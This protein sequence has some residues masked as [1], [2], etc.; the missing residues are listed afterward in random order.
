MIQRRAFSVLRETL[1]RKASV[2]LIGPRQVGKTT[3]ALSLADSVGGT[4]WD[5]ERTDVQIIFEDISG[6]FRSQEGR[7]VI[8][9]EVHR[10]PKLFSSIRGVIDR[11]RREG[12]RN[13]L[14]LFL[15]SASIDLL[16]QGSES[17]AGRLV[18]VDLDPIDVLEATEADIPVTELWIRGGFPYSLTTA[19]DDVSFR[20]RQDFIQTYVERYMGMFAERVPRELLRQIWTMLAYSQ[21]SVLNLSSLGR[22]LGVS[23]PTVRKYVELLE[24]LLLIRRLSPIHT[25][26]KKQLVKSPKVYIRDSGL[27]HA[28]LGLDTE[29]KLRSHPIVGLSWE[30][31]VIENLLRVSPHGTFAGFYRTAKGAEVDLVLDLPGMNERWAIEI[32]RSLSSKL[33]RGFFEAR[34]DLS[35]NRSFL[36]HGGED[37]F[38]MDNDVEVVGLTSICNELS[39][40]STS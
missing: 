16:G 25:N 23:A 40:L 11:S 7:L 15:G 18:F 31:F 3:L 33:T 1:E 13:G 12:N 34:N 10:A 14:F 21:G 9:D 38:R 22:A 28:L 39:N 32:K 27:V 29:L 5:L 35:V 6:F 20:W 2:A 26:V 8:L 30:G 4:Y 17:L 24:K 19:S 37:R 36:V